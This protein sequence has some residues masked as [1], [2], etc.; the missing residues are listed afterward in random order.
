MGNLSKIIHFYDNGTF[1]EFKPKEVKE[2]APFTPTQTHMGTYKINYVGNVPANP[3]KHTP[4]CS[5]CGVPT[6][7]AQLFDS[8]PHRD[9]PVEKISRR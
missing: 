3:P 1:K 9:C 5:Q 6:S 8:C 4:F 2:P 7:D